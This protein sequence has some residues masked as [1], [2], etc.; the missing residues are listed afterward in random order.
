[1]S[2][3]LLAAVG[4]LTAVPAFAA[5]EM[6]TRKAGLWEMKMGLGG[7]GGGGPVVQQ[8]TDAATDKALTASAGGATQDCA[9]RDIKKTAGGMTIDSVCTIAG[10]SVTSHMEVNGSFDSA[11][12]MKITSDAGAQLQSG[13]PSQMTVVMEAKW[14]GPCKA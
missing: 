13:A 11:Y 4:L 5:D 8:C 14:L 3:L 12:T 9:K 10:K 7:A 2:R 6:P 1:M